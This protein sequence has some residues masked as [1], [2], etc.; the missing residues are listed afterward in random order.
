M[1]RKHDPRNRTYPTAKE[2]AEA[3]RTLAEAKHIPPSLRLSFTDID[4]LVS[5]ELR[6]VR[7]MLELMKPESILMKKGIDQ[8]IVIFGSARISEHEVARRKLQ[9]A[10]DL[11]RLDPDNS[12]KQQ[13]V[14]AAIALM[15]KSHYYDE[16]RKLGRL[17][18]EHFKAHDTASRFYVATGGGPGIMEAANRG[19]SEA[20]VENIGFT[21]A[22]PK[23]FPNVYSSN[24]L[25]FQFH[26]FAVRKMHLLLRARALIVFPGGYGTLDELF[27][28][29]T[30]M[31]TYR[32]QPIPILLFGRAYW[33]KIVNFNAMFD[34]GVISTDDL[35]H[36][37]YVETA[38]EAW[39][40]IVATYS[41]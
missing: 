22:I 9:S 33:E 28:T 5:D 24:E 39:A 7:L 18:G 41:L 23:E 8:T 3:Q 13:A 6:P 19:A 37:K 35:S 1:M 15:R 4:F 38:E 31:Q 34:E 26:Y 17:I 25:T 16:A 21:I 32:M 10:E 27:E 30:L 11:L 2:V 14:Q 20:G 12:V 36:I 40:A 29:L